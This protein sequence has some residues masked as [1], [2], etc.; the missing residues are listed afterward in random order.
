M[1]DIKVGGTVKVGLSSYRFH[2][3]VALIIPLN[4]SIILLI[5]AGNKC[6]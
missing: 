2:I 4:N 6:F 3:L 5:N 1:V